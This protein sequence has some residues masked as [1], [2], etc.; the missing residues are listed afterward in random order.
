[1]DSH[2]RSN[3]GPA[4]AVKVEGAKQTTI[5][6]TVTVEGTALS[7][8]PN[9]ETPAATSQP[10]PGRAGGDTNSAHNNT[11][12]ADEEGTDEEGFSVCNWSTASLAGRPEH[13]HG[14]RPCRKETDETSGGK[15]EG[16]YGSS[17]GGEKH[18]YCVYFYKQREELV[19]IH[20]CTWGELKKQFHIE[21]DMCKSGVRVKRFDDPAKAA[22]FFS[23]IRENSI[24]AE[25]DGLGCVPRLFYTFTAPP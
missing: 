2:S 11:T 24:A 5:T 8:N 22:T 1:M 9:V 19:G 4:V 7:G 18:Y 10:P 16:G 15:A 3:T 14:P 12:E 21:E 17:S 6:V 20:Y 25:A 23:C 13:P